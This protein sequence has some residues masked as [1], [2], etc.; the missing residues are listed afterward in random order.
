MKTQR[1]KAKKE[2]MLAKSMGKMIF[3][4]LVGVFTV[5]IVATATL[6][7]RELESAI[8][9]GISMNAENTAHQ[10]QAVLE[11]AES[12]GNDMKQYLEKAYQVGGDSYDNMAK[13]HI[14]NPRV[15]HSIVYADAEISELNADVEK[16]LTETA[17]GAV[18]GNDAILGFGVLFEPY[19][20]DSN[21]ESYAFYVDESVGADG[22]IEP[23]GDYADYSKEVYYKI[24]AE[25]KI[26]V[27]TEPY[28]YEGKIL[29]SYAAPILFNDELQGVILADIDTGSFGETI[30]VNPDYPSMHTTI[31]DGDY[32][33]IYDGEAPDDVGKQMDI[34]FKN[35]KELQSVKD[36]MAKGESFSISTI[37]EDGRKLY[38]YYYPI[39]AA[40]DTWWAMTAIEANDRN[41]AVTMCVIIVTLLSIVSMIIILVCVIRTLL[42]RLAPIEKIVTAAEDISKG[43]INVKVDVHTNDEIGRVAYAFQNTVDMLKIIIGDVDIVLAE[44]AAG[45]FAVK[46]KHAESYIGDFQNILVSMR[47]LKANLGE[48]LSNIVEGAEQVALGSNQM[49]DNAQALA[50]GA[51]EQAGAVE[52][53]TATVENIATISEE[54]AKA[55]KMASTQVDKAAEEAELANQNV[56]S[57]MDAMKRISDTSK[58]IENI[59]VAIED[60]ASQTNLLSLNASIEAARAGEAGKGF[61]VVADQI[62]KLALDSAKSAVTTK[63][64]ITKS[65]E[66][67]DEGNC[68]T[69]KTAEAFK[70]I[71]SNMHQFGTLAKGA[72]E[73]SISQSQMLAQVEQGIEQIST[74]VQTNSASAEETSATS[75]ELSAQADTL[76]L[77]VEKFQLE[78][79]SNG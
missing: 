45:N 25:K 38:R 43:N 39:S 15:Y 9:D 14:E 34:F 61:A 64:L 71:I 49:A 8:G 48:S 40:S 1:K 26:P 54:S 10:I 20:Y 35:Q 21:I 27:F 24:A 22:D 72:S 11:S 30:K 41:R 75:E 73:S 36:G 29:I 50:E 37:R 18:E 68:I 12:V 13:E 3:A 51:T 28:E 57:L 67:I 16:Y 56:V 4:V 55:A 66:E 6:T 17:R 78:P 74:V 77:L 63:D 46:S 52:E 53:L 65:L 42:K 23:F 7:G 33:D 79:R 47:K 32:T 44:M 70:S 62:G 69:E 60:I 76:K 31:Y 59:I 58:E 19:K 5:L 2:E